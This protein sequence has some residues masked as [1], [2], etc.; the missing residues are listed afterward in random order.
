MVDSLGDNWETVTSYNQSWQ[1][2]PTKHTLLQLLMLEINSRKQ[3]QPS[4]NKQ[5][6]TFLIGNYVRPKTSMI[7]NP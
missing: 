4:F 1:E 2:S 7:K 3:H 5:S 6:I